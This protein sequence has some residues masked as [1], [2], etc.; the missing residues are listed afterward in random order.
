[1]TLAGWAYIALVFILVLGGAV[2]LGRYI[3]RILRGDRLFLAPVERG[4]YAICG[5]DAERAMRWQDYTVALLLLS[6]IHMVLLYA[7]LRLQQYLPFNPQHIGPMSPRLAFNTAA[8]FT[9]NTNWQSYAPESQISNGAQMF[10]LAVHMFISAAAGIAVAGAVMR[11]F[12]GS[13]LQ[14]LGNFY[15]DLTRVTLYLLLPVTIIVGLVLVWSGSPQTFAPFAT[16]HTLLG[17]SQTIAVGPVAMQEAIKEFGTNGGGFFNA[18][19]A[20]PFENPTIWTNLLENWL[21]LVIGFALPIAFGAMIGKPRQGYALYGAMA[22][23]LVT[24]CIGTYAAESQGNPLHIA[25][26]V[27]AGPGNMEGKEVRFGIAASTTFNT[28]ATG[29]STGAVDSFTDSYMPLAGAVPILLMQLGEVTPGGV[30]SGFYT[31]IIFALLSVFVAGLMV[32]RTPEYLGKKVQAREIKLA[33]LSVL[34]LTFFILMGSGFSLVTASG[35]GSL[36]NAGPHGLSEMLYA[37]TSATEN[38]GSAM[39][40]LSADT[41]MLDYGLG[42]AMLFGRFAFMIPVLA[43]AGSL[44]AKPKLPEGSGTFPTDNA[45][46]VALLIGVIIILG[47]LQFMPADTLGPLAEHFAL[48]SGKSY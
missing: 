21:L 26:G 32:G 7:I 10:G 14:S 27:S 37:W 20:H 33:M 3:A 12:T 5:I 23:I 19:S 38:N 4:I 35:L 16:A 30:G 2:P 45:L 36:A 34:I 9:T 29:T 42:T 25:A 47:G 13:G 15:V 41:P 40:G 11:A 43:I 6:V 44:A 22:I 24:A 28:S 46:F 18:N 8:S 48:F 39:A 31:I 17:G 1:M